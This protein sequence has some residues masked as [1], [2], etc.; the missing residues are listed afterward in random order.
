MRTVINRSPWNSKRCQLL[1][2]SIYVTSVCSV[3]AFPHKLHLKIPSHSVV[4]QFQESPET[5]WRFHLGLRS[6]MLL[7]LRAVH[8]LRF[9]YCMLL[10]QKL[11]AFKRWI[12]T[13]AFKGG[14]KNMLVISGWL[15]A[16]A[17]LE[18]LISESF[19]NY[20]FRFLLT[21]RFNQDALEVICT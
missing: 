9:Q 7:I 6:H 21:G 12:E 15:Q 16:I 11:A 2:T 4:T 8:E 14:R 20:Q 18:M 3:S 19:T 13:W 10:F 5:N 17:G 1:L